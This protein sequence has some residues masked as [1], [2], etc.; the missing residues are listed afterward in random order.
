MNI[1]SIRKHIVYTE[2]VNDIM[3]L[4]QDTEDTEKTVYTFKGSHS[5]TFTFAS[6]FISSISPFFTKG[7]NFWS[8]IMMCG[9]MFCMTQ[10]N[11]LNNSD[12]I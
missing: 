11:P 8:L 9:H 6:L 4:R 3:S 10:H 12:V 7:N 1:I 5:T 2:V